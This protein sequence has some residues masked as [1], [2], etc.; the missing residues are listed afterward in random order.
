MK[1][2]KK[3]PL[4]E[5]I[6]G[7]I[8]QATARGEESIYVVLSISDASLIVSA[9]QCMKEYAKEVIAEE[10]KI[11]SAYNSPYSS[12]VEGMLSSDYKER[13]K[14]EYQ[15]TKI[16]HEKLKAFNNRI[17]AANLPMVDKKCEM[18]K[19]DCPKYMLR[20]QQKTMEEYLHLLEVRAVLEG[21]EL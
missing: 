12:T 6:N 21:I 20:E 5:T 14:A 19:H 4:E 8:E 2:E 11:K 7:K 15:Q 3:N 10:N 13:F 17:E 9:L 1:M 18:P 16:R